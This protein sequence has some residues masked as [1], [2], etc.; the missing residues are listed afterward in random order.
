MTSS[1]TRPSRVVAVVATLAALAAAPALAGCAPS[2]SSDGDAPKGTT[3][4]KFQLDWVKNSQFSGF[5]SAEDEGYFADAGLDVQFLDGGDVASTASVIA[6]GGAQLGIVSNMARLYDANAS[7]ADLVAV[8]ALYQTSPAG[9]MTT[10]DREVT[11]VDDL[12]GLKIGTDEAG[13][14]DIDSLFKVN[15]DEPDWTPVR[16]GFDAAPLFAG[17]I[18]AYYCYVTNQPVTSELQGQESNVVT[19]A[20]LGFQSYAGLIVATRKYL[21]SHRDD[22]RAFLTAAQKGWQ[23]VADDPKAAVSLTLSSYGA[24]LGLDEATELG[25]LEAQLPLMQSAFSQEH[26]LLALD[27]DAIAGPMYDALRASGRTDLP[28]PQEVYD[29]AL[30]EETTSSG[31]S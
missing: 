22:V 6:G 17:K 13:Q 10:P 29:T 4:I 31:Q 28:D 19:F 30:L 7:G 1:F 8:G 21:D 3:S 2:A 5:F 12:V 24:S 14:P 20:D 16:V 18:D 27:V 25:T 11:S 9:I 26:G 15:G 23:K